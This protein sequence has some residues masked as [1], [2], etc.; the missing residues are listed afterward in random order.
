MRRFL[1]LAVGTIAAAGALVVAA[2]TSTATADREPITDDSGP[3][4]DG[5]LVGPAEGGAYDAGTPQGPEPDCTTYC[6]QVMGS[7][8]GPHAQYASA[9]Q[10]HELCQRLPAGDAGDTKNNTLACRQYYAGSPARTSA[11][12][13]C[14]AAGPFGGGVCGDRCIAFCALTLGACSPD[15]GPAPYESYPAC[16]TACAGYSYLDGGADGGGEPPDGPTT[17]NTL[18]CRLFHVRSAIHDGSGCAD[19]GP[20]A[21]DCR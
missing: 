19:L 3:R 17:G 20:D 15:A 2:C 16:Q 14:L 11:G 10:C 21:G 8:T 18:N 6:E 4:I 1:F 7:C 9:S 5:G 13:Y 12:D